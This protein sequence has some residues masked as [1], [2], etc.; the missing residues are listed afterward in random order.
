MK[1]IDSIS[2]KNNIFR[3]FEKKGDNFIA[4]NQ[5]Y[6][7]KQDDN[8]KFIFINS[9]DLNNAS[10][11]I[12]I[13]YKDNTDDIYILKNNKGLSEQYLDLILLSNI[14]L[15]LEDVYIN[16]TELIK[17]ILSSEMNMDEKL[18]EDLYFNEEFSKK[19]NI[20]LPQ[21]YNNKKVIL[22]DVDIEKKYL[23]KINFMELTRSFYQYIE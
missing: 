13:P 5:F 17:S 7:S 21:R 19:I 4:T 9:N 23:F 16:K 14:S 3:E 10:D 1:N 15:S 2:K 18:L 22:E 6:I 20:E 11:K 12:I 8:G